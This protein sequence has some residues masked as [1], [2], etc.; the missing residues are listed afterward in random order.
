VS[1]QVYGKAREAW[2]GGLI[3]WGTGT[4]GAAIHLDFVDLADYTVSIASHEF[5]SSVPVGARVATAGP[6]V[7]KSATLGALDATDHTVTGV[8]GDQFEAVIL[9]VNTGSDATS[10][11]LIFIDTASGLPGTPVGGD[12]TVAWDNGANKI[13]TL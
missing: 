11:L 8:T 4:T 12:F 5:R 9:F 13:A 3:N 7:G 10:R 6:L 2:A 1:N